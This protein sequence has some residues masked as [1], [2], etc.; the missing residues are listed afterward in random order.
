MPARE[1]REQIIGTPHKALLGDCIDTL[2]FIV[3]QC[4]RIAALNA[5]PTFA[6]YES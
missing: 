3:R 2:S 6:C 4:E 5:C 1:R